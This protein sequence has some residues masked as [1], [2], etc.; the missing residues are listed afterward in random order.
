MKFEENAIEIMFFSVKGAE[1]AS[2]VNYA[3]NEKKGFSDK[4]LSFENKTW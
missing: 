1:C 2:Q 4:L 3:L